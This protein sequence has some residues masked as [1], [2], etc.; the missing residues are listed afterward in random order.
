M[1]RPAKF[2]DILPLCDL[3]TEAYSR[4]V[5]AMRATLDIA[6]FKALCM[7]AIRHHGGSGCLFVADHGAGPVGFIM[8]ATDRLYGVSRERYASDLF[9]YVSPSSAHALDA[10]RL[11]LAFLR[12]AR[13]AP[14]VIE[15]HMGVSDAITDHRRTAKTLRRAG[16]EKFGEIYVMR[17]DRAAVATEAA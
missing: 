10:D 13:K 1:I 7:G 11:K 15:V 9:T 3:M 5:Y 8:G 2:S 14:G 12:W 16:L 17:L 4:S 6:A